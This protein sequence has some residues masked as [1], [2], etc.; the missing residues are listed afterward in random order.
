[1]NTATYL[2]NTS[3]VRIFRTHLRAG[4][5]FPANLPRHVTALTL[6]VT[7]L[8]AISLARV[9][10][11]AQMIKTIPEIQK[12]T[13]P[14]GGSDGNFGL[15]VALSGNLAIVGNPQDPI[16]GFDSGSASIFAFDGTSWNLQAK[17]TANGEVAFDS[18]GSAVAISGN[19]ALIGAP[20]DSTLASLAGAVYVF[21]FDG[22][23]WTQQAKLFA[24]DP[25][26]SALFGGAL[27]V[28]GDT[29]LIGAYFSGNGSAYVFKFDGTAWSEQAKLTAA[30]GGTSDFFGSSVALSENRAL[31]G[32]YSNGLGGAAYVFSFDGTTW[33]QE[34]KLTGLDTR[35]D[36]QFGYAVALS[37]DLALIGAPNRDQ[38]R[39]AAYVFA[40]DGTSWSQ[41][42]KFRI[43]GAMKFEYFGSSVALT[44]TT[45][46]V[47]ARNVT[48]PGKIYQ[49]SLRRNVWTLRAQF[50]PTDSANGDRLG[51]SLALSGNSVLGG[52]DDD[53]NSGSGSA[54]IFKLGR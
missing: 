17:L 50:I 51:V 36:D 3:P 41:Q 6:S 43:T 23:T 30:D 18:F 15:V 52:A 38:G 47:G 5:L 24:S 25:A 31:V 7:L 14:D 32:A 2:M 11:A 40:Y 20:L 34:A 39:G 27:A 49:Y 33:S 13:D 21:T 44:P 46:L 29:A 8:L 4:H 37:G 9:A 1:M 54:Y 53:F 16:K 28:S 12:L 19:M 10:P 45:S 42:T 26:T 48:A 35:E 22:T